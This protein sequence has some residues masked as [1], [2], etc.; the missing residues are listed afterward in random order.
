MRSPIFTLVCGGMLFS[1]ASSGSGMLYLRA[2]RISVS[3]GATT[4][5]IGCVGA[6]LD[7][8]ALDWRTGGGRLCGDCACGGACT[9]PVVMGS[10]DWPG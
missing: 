3:P 5:T 1:R 9:E 10:G 7:A 2:M 6:I 8:G 4:C